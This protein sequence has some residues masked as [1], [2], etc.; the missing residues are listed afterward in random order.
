MHKIHMILCGGILLFL[1]GSI[2]YNLYQKNTDSVANVV[3]PET[4]TQVEVP[5]SYEE[6]VD[7]NGPVTVTVKPIDI[8]EESW[9]FEVTLQTHSVDLDMDILESVT[10][11]DPEGEEILPDI[12][13]GD[14]PGGHHRTG[15]LMFQKIDPMPDEIRVLVKDVGEASLREFIW[16]TIRE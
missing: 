5:N 3:T 6:Q 12:W 7:E 10:L 13:D 4:R 9:D 16:P 11:L 1:L 8:S 2:G 15:I 14:A